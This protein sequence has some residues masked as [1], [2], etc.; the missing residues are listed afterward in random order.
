MLVPHTD[1]VRYPTP[2]YRGPQIPYRWQRV[3]YRFPFDG[4]DTLILGNGQGNTEEVK[5]DR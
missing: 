3:A 4:P 1:M 5:R 2:G